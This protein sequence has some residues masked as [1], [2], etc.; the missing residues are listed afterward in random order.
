MEPIFLRDASGTGLLIEI[1]YVKTQVAHLKKFRVEFR[2]V[3]SSLSRTLI[4]NL[5]PATA[6]PAGSL[7]NQQKA[8]DPLKGA[9][10]LFR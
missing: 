1:V 7:E 5:L 6:T 2:S 3:Y 9:N 8:P 10:L 4:L